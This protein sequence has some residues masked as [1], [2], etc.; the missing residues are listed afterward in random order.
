MEGFFQLLLNGAALGSI[1]ALIALGYTLVYGIL[2]LI[3]FAHGDLVMVGAYAGLFASLALGAADHPSPEKLLLVLGIAMA[4]AGLVG[5]AI[6]RFAYRPLRGVPRLNLLIT[7][8]G[9]SLLLENLGQVFFGA[10]PR[11]FPDLLPSVNLWQS[12]QVAVT[13]QQAV[14]FGTALGL[15]VV[16][17]WIVQK[18][19]LGRAM[20]AVAHSHETAALVGIPV[21]MVIAF[22]F[23]V[24]SAL[25]AAAG[26]LIGI[27]YPR[28]DPLMGIMIGMKA[29]VAAV[30]GGI[31]SIR[32][33]VVGGFLMGILE[34]MVV[35]YGSSTYRDALAFVI[36]ILIL[37]F[38]PA[39]L[40][41]KYQP[42]K[43]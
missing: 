18:T 5:I 43:V 19:R 22:T 24:G 4:A 13:N 29:F 21:D 14:V 39:G 41:G 8:V 37:L 40:F 3:N 31:G 30:L 7:A 35:G 42:E 23:A 34:A 15:M 33:A 27:S 11:V 26:V 16:L 20:R 1:Y 9:V 36:L 32:G 6:E 17:E 2:S 25:A 12:G 38:R 28:V 10:T